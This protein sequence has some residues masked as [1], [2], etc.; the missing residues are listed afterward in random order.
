MCGKAELWDVSDAP[1][2]AQAAAALLD[3]AFKPVE[4]AHYG[5]LVRSG[6]VLPWKPNEAL[7]LQYPTEARNA[8]RGS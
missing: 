6:Q 8:P 5:P 2:P 4:I 3:L 1:T 7:R